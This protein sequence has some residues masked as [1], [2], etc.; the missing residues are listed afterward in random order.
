MKF[1]LFFSCVLVLFLSINIYALDDTHLFV[2]STLP[3][4]IKTIGEAAEYYAQIIGYTLKITPPAPIE[5]ARISDEPISIL[6][7]KGMIIPIDEA[8][9]GLL[10]EEYSLVIDKEHK[11]FSFKEVI[12]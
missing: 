12:Q 10:K 11:L 4:E 3:P 8:I 1:K 9:L 2:R 5:S 7:K 6:V